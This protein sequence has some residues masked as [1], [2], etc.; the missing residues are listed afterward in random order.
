MATSRIAFA[1]A[2]T[3]VLA[4]CAS[5]GDEQM[6]YAPAARNGAT[7]QEDTAYMQ[8]VEQQARIRGIGVTW[9]N[10]PIKRTRVA[11]TPR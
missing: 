8:R 10:P 6:A 5:M 7:V 9:V 11:T 2:A 1:F 3:L 4:G